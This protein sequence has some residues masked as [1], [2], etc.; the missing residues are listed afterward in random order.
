MRSCST[1]HTST[2]FAELSALTVIPTAKLPSTIRFCA[3]STTAEEIDR[4]V[5]FASFTASMYIVAHPDYVR[6]VRIVPTGPESTEL[7]VD[8]LLPETTR[9]AGP[10]DLLPILELARTVIREDGEACELNQRGLRSR[11]F[12]AGVLVG[13]EYDLWTFHEWLRSRVAD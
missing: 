7:V 9:L 10:D 12:A 6:T 2:T 3:G 4:G 8:W 1:S 13:Q 11:R 5:A